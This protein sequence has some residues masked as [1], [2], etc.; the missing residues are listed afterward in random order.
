MSAWSTTTSGSGGGAVAADGGG[1]A[2]AVDGGAVAVDGGAGRP[3]APG[4]RV[5]AMVLT[6]DEAHHLPDCL[7]SL[8]WADAVLVLDSGSADGS[9]D[10]ARARG[11]TVVEHRF[12]NYSRQRNAALDLVQTAW[13][14]FVDA[15][16]R[17][18]A[19]LAEEI[20]RTLRAPRAAAY[21][22]PRANLFWGHRM[23][24]G[25]WWPDR[26]LRLL[27]VDSVR[28]DPARAVHELAQV[29]GP[30][31]HLSQ[32]L[33]HLNYESPGE[34]WRKQRR[35]AA[36]DAQRRRAEGWTLRRRQYLTMPAREFARRYVILSGWRDGLA[37]LVACG[38]M[39]GYELLVLRRLAQDAVPAG[40]D[41]P[42]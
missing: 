29:S 42:R 22:L 37:G 16:E 8:A 12:V 28:Y 3:G 19:T 17:V 25:G 11:A 6:L 23:R 39:A 31:G 32:P 10:I 4:E 35:Y 40:V 27:R 13:V 26:Q 9:R 18:P 30:S 7:A 24:G 38:L 21:G 33:V 36:L 2:T 14:L 5:T 41:E 15:D 34:L 1:G 20:R